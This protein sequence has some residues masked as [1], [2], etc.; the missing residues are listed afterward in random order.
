MAF[1]P[2]RLLFR[3]GPVLAL[4]G[5][6]DNIPGVKSKDLHDGLRILLHFFLLAA[7]GFFTGFIVP[8]FFREGNY[9]GPLFFMKAAAHDP[10][11]C[12]QNANSCRFV[13]TFLQA[14]I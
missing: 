11:L 13:C 6:H 4:W 7:F 5:S 2:G 10:P 1:S 9:P 8:Q 3:G 14:V 12:E